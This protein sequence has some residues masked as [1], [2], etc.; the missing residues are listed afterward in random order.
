MLNPDF[1]D[2]LSALNAR[3][4]EYMVVGA[5]AL[6]AH[7]YL[8]AT[9]DI[10]IWVRCTVENA[11]K[12]LQALKD[13]GTPMF[14][15]TLED[16]SSPGIVFQIGLPP[17]RIDF[18]TSISGVDF[19]KCWADRMKV[20]V[21]GLSINFLSK[22]WLIANKRATGRPKDILDADELERSSK[23]D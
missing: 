2:M 21:D 8:R 1:S 6:A 16:L 14:D 23:G 9:G 15:L 22:P 12:V 13:F 18:L 7:G 19:D 20:E 10:D 4:A 17:R 5:Y 11:E 3:K